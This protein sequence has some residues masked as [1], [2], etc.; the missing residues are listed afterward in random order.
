M[1]LKTLARYSKAGGLLVACVAAA[2]IL[3]TAYQPGQ[4][5][6]I[7]MPTALPEE[8][9]AEVVLEAAVVEP[10]AAT[11]ATHPETTKAALV[12]RPEV[13]KVT[14]SKAPAPRAAAPKTVAANATAVKAAVEPAAKTPVVKL[15]AKAP[16]QESD[17]VTL[18]GCLER[19]KRTFRLKDTAGSDAPKSR[20]WKS[21]FLKKGSATIDVVDAANRLKLPDHV[22]ER[23][24]V[25]G[26]LVDREMSARSLRRIEAS[27][28]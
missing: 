6:D 8:A 12:A 20:S 15:G 7:A 26:T 27:C 3:I 22:G 16:V 17:V 28:E 5:T 9:A 4:P 19:D 10:V 23:V 2:A 25:T 11:A 14:A 13:K 24:S 21:G 18:T 1:L